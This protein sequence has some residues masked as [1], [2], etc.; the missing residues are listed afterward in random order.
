MQ[1][2]TMV[3][4]QSRTPSESITSGLVRAREFDPHSS[5]AVSFGIDRTERINIISGLCSTR[6]SNGKVIRFPASI[7]SLPRT[8]KYQYYKLL[9]KIINIL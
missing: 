4:Y 7:E 3:L 1:G 2:C 6:E 8:Y 9:T 5:Y